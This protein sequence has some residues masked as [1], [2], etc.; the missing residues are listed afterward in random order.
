[1]LTKARRR[2]MPH[3]REREALTAAIIYER[4]RYL[5]SRVDELAARMRALEDAHDI[6]ATTPCPAHREAA[7][8]RN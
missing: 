4:L 5:T 3:T 1:M 7:C 6:I 2:V 8:G